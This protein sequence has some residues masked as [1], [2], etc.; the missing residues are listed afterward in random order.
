MSRQPSYAPA[1]MPIPAVSP[2]GLKRRRIGWSALLLMCFGAFV[3]L[4]FTVATAR[5][6][7]VR[8]EREILALKKKQRDLEIEFQSRANQHRLANW[9]RVEY[10]YDAPRADQFFDGRRQLAQLGAPRASDAPSPI[11]VAR[12]DDDGSGSVSGEPRAMVSPVSGAPI[13]LAAVNTDD[14]ATSAFAEAFGDA[15]IEASPIRQARA[16]TGDR[17]ASG[18]VVSES[19]Q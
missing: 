3:V 6:E 16:E 1:S 15:L 14:S 7:V 10:G 11:R 12:L 17:L 13:T 8:T 2:T 5:N 9:N 4:S 19:G 18:G